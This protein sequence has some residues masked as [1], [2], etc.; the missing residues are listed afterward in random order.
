[1]TVSFEFAPRRRRENNQQSWGAVAE[2][3]PGGCGARAGRAA[4]PGHAEPGPRGT[5]GRENLALPFPARPEGP[6]RPQVQPQRHPEEPLPPPAGLAPRPRPSLTCQPQLDGP[7]P[8]GPRV[9]HG[10]GRGSP[11][12]AP[13]RARGRREW[14]RAGRSGQRRPPEE[15][16][17]EERPGCAQR[18]HERGRG[19]GGGAEPSPLPSASLRFPAP[20]PEHNKAGTEPHGRTGWRRARLGCSRSVPPSCPGEALPAPRAPP[21]VGPG[22]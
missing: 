17:K 8:P 7:V 3:R 19:R 15:E 16:E 22:A 2:V 6:L 18:R 13:P 5:E 4:E 14:S 12:A 21:R 1:M 9:G 10:P 11:A 20:G